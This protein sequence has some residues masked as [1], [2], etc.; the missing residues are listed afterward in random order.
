M[1][2]P[3][4]EQL[5]AG[6]L[7]V[8]T[9]VG[10]AVLL[11]AG[12][13]ATVDT[14]SADEAVR[15]AAEDAD[16]VVPD[17]TAALERAAAAPRL[18]ASQRDEVEWVTSQMTVPHEAAPAVVPPG[19]AWERRPTIDAGVAAPDGM[20]ALVL[21]GTIRMADGRAAPSGVR[22]QVR[23]MRLSVM[24]GADGTWQVLH[25]IDEIGATGVEDATTGRRIPDLDLP[26]AEQDGSSLPAPT[27]LE[28][29]V[30]FRPANGR[31]ILGDQDV[32]A[33][34]VSYEARLVSDDPEAAPPDRAR[35]VAHVGASWTETTTSPDRVDVGAG[36][37]HLLTTQWQP[38][39]MTTV[40]HGEL[41]PMPCVRCEA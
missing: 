33:V 14:S 19:A 13:R 26:R 29:A 34:L 16:D 11:G 7:V 31:T 28:Q 36:R 32:A 12:V 8:A 24:D 15:P 25:D 30:W 1:R 6:A 9:G 17:A 39:T 23:K 22:V 3:D 4:V 38:L 35:V 5:L 2:V 27:G 18:T 21:W 41:V 40:R 10:V 37:F 20:P